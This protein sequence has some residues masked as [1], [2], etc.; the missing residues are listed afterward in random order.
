MSLISALQFLISIL[1]YTGPT[2]RFMD[3]V[4][5]IPSRTV[6]ALMRTILIFIAPV[7]IYPPPFILP[8]EDLDVQDIRI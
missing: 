8:I 7:K 1:R 4:K 2:G 3:P 6:Q 5:Q